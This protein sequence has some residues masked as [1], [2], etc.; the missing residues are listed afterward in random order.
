MTMPA[1]IIAAEL[2]NSASSNLAPQKRP[3]VFYVSPSYLAAH[4]G[5]AAELL[6]RMNP[7]S[8]LTGEYYMTLC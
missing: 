4:I 7:D 5:E 2:V 1:Q 3:P 8:K 6:G